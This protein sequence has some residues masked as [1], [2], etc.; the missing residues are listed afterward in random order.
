M[1]EQHFLCLGQDPT[2]SAAC[3][4]WSRLTLVLAHSDDDAC[5]EAKACFIKVTCQAADGLLEQLARS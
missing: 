5:A 4:L 1:G 3:Q 2:T